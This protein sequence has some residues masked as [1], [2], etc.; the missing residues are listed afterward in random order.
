MSEHNQELWRNGA[1]VVTEMRA[2]ASLRQASR[3]FDLDPR[4]VLQL[5]RPA[6]RKRRNGRW[7]A[8]KSDRLLRVL[9]M[10]TPK[11]LIDIGVPDSKQA[12]L[13][14]KY[15]NAVDL[16]LSTGDSSA[17]WFFQGKYITE[18]HEGRVPFITDTHELD[19]LGSAGNMSFESLYARVA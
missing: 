12:T 15:W 17:L 9:P 1:Q 14:G 13:V 11:G 6:L 8:K 4:K 7:A 18:A 19:R 5:V 2:G 3:K 10:P 16:Y